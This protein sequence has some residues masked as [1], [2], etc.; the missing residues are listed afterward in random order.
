[1]P[2]HSAPIRTLHDAADQLE[3]ILAEVERIL[4]EA[5]LLERAHHL[6]VAD[7][8]A[9]VEGM[10]DDVSETEMAL[11][12]GFER[13]WCASYTICDVLQRIDLDLS[14]AHLAPVRHLGPGGDR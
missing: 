1:M 13:Y 6:A 12:S 8:G 5:H 4:D 3:A 9:I 14:D 7:A 11:A 2:N 10:L